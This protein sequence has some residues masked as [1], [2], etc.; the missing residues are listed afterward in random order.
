[1]TTLKTM[2]RGMSLVVFMLAVIASDTNHRIKLLRGS[3]IKDEIEIDS[4]IVAHG[5]SE[6]IVESKINTI[7][8]RIEQQQ[9][10]MQPTFHTSF[11]S[12]ASYHGYISAHRQV[13][14]TRMS[15]H[16]WYDILLFVISTYKY[17][18][19]LSSGIRRL[20]W[21]AVTRG[22]PAF[23]TSAQTY[24]IIRLKKVFFDMSWSTVGV[25]SSKKNKGNP[26]SYVSPIWF[27]E[28]W[29]IFEREH[30]Y[31]AGYLMR[32]WAFS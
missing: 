14:E 22:S 7:T 4:S 26:A 19:N 20:G 23:S 32:S 6:S 27:Y 17:G 1:M 15:N 12:S 30:M 18:D 9:H 25:S 21:N 5:G 2:L 24:D 28:M 11:H 29:Y 8:Q 10:T 31:P 16:T 3:I 13:A